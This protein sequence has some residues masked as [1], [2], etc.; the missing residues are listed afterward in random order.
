MEASSW[1]RE[2][3]PPSCDWSSKSGALSPG[4][5]LPRPQVPSVIFLRE[6]EPFLMSR[7]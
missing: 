5:R 4:F 6:S 7:S 1:W 2:T 3:L